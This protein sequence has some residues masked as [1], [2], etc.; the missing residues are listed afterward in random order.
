M[1][2]FKQYGLAQP[3]LGIVSPTEG[4]ATKPMMQNRESISSDFQK[5]AIDMMSFVNE[6][7][8]MAPG[9]TPNPTIK[10]DDVKSYDSNNVIPEVGHVG[11]SYLQSKEGANN[12]YTTKNMAGSSAYGRY[13]IMPSTGK[14]VAS[15]IGIDPGS[16]DVPENQDK[17]MV[18]LNKDYSNRLRD[19][20]IDDT[21]K[22]RYA[23]HQ[24]GG[25]R[26]GRYFNNTLT[27]KDYGVMYDNLPQNMRSEATSKEAIKALWKISYNN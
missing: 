7:D 9:F 12:T 6:P 3:G 22:N 16:W 21:E 19:L 13:Q 14:W 24:L 18:Q 26:A 25:A 1:I 8:P 15:R 23:V 2:N 10:G 17:V 11:G 4:L 20:N 27:D 5:K